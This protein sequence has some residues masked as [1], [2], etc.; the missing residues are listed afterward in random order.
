MLDAAELVF[1]DIGYD[2]ATTNQIAATAETSIGS[3]YEFFSNKQAVARALADRYMLELAARCDEALSGRSDGQARV[4]ML[5]DAADEFQDLHPGLG[6]LLRG[7]R[8]SIELRTVRRAFESQLV[9]LAER[10]LI[11][12][13]GPCDPAQ[14]NVVAT[15]CMVTLVMVLDGLVAEVALTHPSALTEVKLSLSSYVAAALPA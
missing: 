13:V 2:A 1:A 14:R 7:T 8:E 11:Q 10:A 12:D 6:P 5:V 9:A 4:A 3:I 15:N